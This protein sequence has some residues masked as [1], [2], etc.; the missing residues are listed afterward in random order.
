MMS[1]IMMRGS[2]P[3]RF[4][5]SKISWNRRRNLRKKINDQLIFNLVIFLAMACI[6]RNLD[7]L[8]KNLWKDIPAS[9]HTYPMKSITTKKKRKRLWSR[10]FNIHMKNTSRIN[11]MHWCTVGTRIGSVSRLETMILHVR[12]SHMVANEVA[13]DKICGSYEK[14]HYSVLKNF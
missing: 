1:Q 9:N 12:F 3:T 10:K 7:D 4:K 8:G 2:F 14:D 11:H 13:L 6:G 5:S